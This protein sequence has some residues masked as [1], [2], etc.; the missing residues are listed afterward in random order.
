M[1]SLPLSMCPGEAISYHLLNCQ[2]AAQQ[3]RTQKERIMDLWVSI[4]SN[5]SKAARSLERDALIDS[6]P[7]LLEN[8][9]EALSNGESVA[10]LQQSADIGKKHGETRAAIKEY[11]VNE[12]IIEYIILSKIIF[13]V[14]QEKLRIDLQ[15]ENLLNDAIHRG[16]GNATAEF[17]RIRDESIEK[18]RAQVEETFRHLVEGVK[19]Y[20]IFTLDTKGFITT[21][22]TGAV[23]MKQYTVAEAVGQ[24]YSMLYPEEG[25]LRN[26]P[27]N[28]LKIAAINGRFRG[29]GLRVKKS[30]ET[31]LADVLITPI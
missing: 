7:D 25:K 24:H 13:S 27:I 2:A 14:L 3:I 17:I 5:E 22:N 1:Q 9:A 16:I 18:E 8:M 28:H 31:F 29:E 20:A 23:R 21:W 6:L 11:P 30:G 15:T 10:N 19:D 4:A 26:E 12:V